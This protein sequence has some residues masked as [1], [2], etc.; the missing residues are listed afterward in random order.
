MSDTDDTAPSA[1]HRVTA[2]GVDHIVMNVADVEATIEW[3]ESRFNVCVERLDEWRSGD[4]PFPWVRLTETLIIDLWESAPTGTNVDHVAFVT[5]P[6]SFGRFAHERADEIEMGPAQMG[7][8][9]GVGRGLY[10]RDPSDNR[11]EIR[12][13]P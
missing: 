6:T 9:Q 10:L 2:T 3:W 11:I 1:S 5:D 8:A 4:A 12:T 13:Y 7:G